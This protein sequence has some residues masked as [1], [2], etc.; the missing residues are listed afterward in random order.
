MHIRTNA[1]TVGRA[2][3]TR[4]A[5]SVERIVERDYAMD[6]EEINKI[7]ERL[8]PVAYKMVNEKG[9]VDLRKLTGDEA[10]TYFAAMGIPIGRI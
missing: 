3:S 6:D 9:Q 5:A 8:G 1:P 10:L 7:E 4:G 2:E